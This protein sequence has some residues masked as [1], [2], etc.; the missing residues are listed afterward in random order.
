M[1]NQPI[2]LKSNGF[3]LES[4]EEV[5]LLMARFLDLVENRKFFLMTQSFAI[6]DEKNQ[7]FK[8]SEI[9]PVPDI[10]PKSARLAAR[11]GE[12]LN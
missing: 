7:L 8:E 6:K 10:N 11:S 4:R 5:R 1:N 2:K 12:S 3:H 9:K